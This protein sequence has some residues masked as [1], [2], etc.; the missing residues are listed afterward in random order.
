MSFLTQKLVLEDQVSIVRACRV[1]DLDRSMFYYESVKDDS[2]VEAKLTS[3]LTN[4]LLCKRGCPEYCKR[5]RREGVTWN[6]KRTERIYR[7]MGLSR[8]RKKQRR[9]TNPEKRPLIQP[10]TLNDT[11]SMDFVEDR[12]ENGRKIRTLNILDDYNLAV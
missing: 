5:I 9:L 10:D 1:V 6:H 4:K 2:D 3:S 11:W 7:N 12:L 8:R